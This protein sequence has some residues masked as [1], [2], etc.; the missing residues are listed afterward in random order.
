MYY[1]DY[2][3]VRLRDAGGDVGELPSESVIPWALG[4]GDGQW[5]DSLRKESQVACFC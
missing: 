2:V 3:S 1:S 4:V 5:Q